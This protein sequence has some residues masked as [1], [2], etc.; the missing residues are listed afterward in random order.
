MVGFSE[1]VGF[2]KMVGFAPLRGAKPT[3][4]LSLLM[5]PYEEIKTINDRDCIIIYS[6]K[7]ILQR[8]FFVPNLFCVKLIMFFGNAAFA[9]RLG[10][11]VL[12]SIGKGYNSKGQNKFGTKSYWLDELNASSPVLKKATCSWSLFACS[13]RASLAT[14]AC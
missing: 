13:R 1:M 6:A 14:A 11:S 2:S 3:L 5:T 12:Y 7:F 4:Q 10:I 8:F 9:Y